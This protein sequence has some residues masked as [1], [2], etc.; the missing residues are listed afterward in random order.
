MQSVPNA[1]SERLT[2]PQE[3]SDE[4]VVARIRAG[5]R[6]LFELLMRRH[7]QRLYRVA[8]S[9]LRDDAEAEDVLQEAYVRA[10]AHLDQ[11]VGRSRFATWLTRIAVHEALHRC[12]RRRRFADFDAVAETV[13][14]AAPGPEASTF[15]GELRDVLEASIDHIPEH[16]R[17]V[18]VLREVEGL[19]TEETA[20]CLSIPPETVKTRLHRA[21]RQLRAQLDRALDSA[22]HDAFGFG[23]HRCDRLVAAVLRRIGERGP[24]SSEG[25]SSVAD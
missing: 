17:T 18:F 20:A 16:F 3:L 9:I 11:F 24:D 25:P 7:N 22:L 4:D 23:L 21:R 5:D 19:S 1:T 6:S 2:S 10:F 12:R 8:R 13:E 15:H 14:S